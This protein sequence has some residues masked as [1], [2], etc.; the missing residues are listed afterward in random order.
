MIVYKMSMNK[1]NNNISSVG[2]LQNR[3]CNTDETLLLTAAI[4]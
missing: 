1:N 3:H 2:F 4:F